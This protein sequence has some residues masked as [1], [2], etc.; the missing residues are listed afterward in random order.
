MKQITMKLSTAVFVMVAAATAKLPT[1]SAHEASVATGFA[2]RHGGLRKLPS[3][4]TATPSGVGGPNDDT[5]QSPGDDTI[6]NQDDG[7]KIEAEVCSTC[8]SIYDTLTQAGSSCQSQCEK[9]FQFDT[10]F[11]RT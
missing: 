8:K 11:E 2:L 5:H 4:S 6:T 9:A 7:T 3:S 10:H 1:A